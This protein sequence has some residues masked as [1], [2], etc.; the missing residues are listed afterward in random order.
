VSADNQSLHGTLP[1]ISSAILRAPSGGGFARQRKTHGFEHD[2]Q[3]RAI[4]LGKSW[5][6]PKKTVRFAARRETRPAEWSHGDL[7]PKFHHAMVT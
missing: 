2:A 5:V 7:N 6:Y 1:A 3:N 4:E